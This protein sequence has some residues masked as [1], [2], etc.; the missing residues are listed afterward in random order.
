MMNPPSNTVEQFIEMLPKAELHMHLEGSLEP[1]MLLR[2]ARRNGIPLR[3]QS[4]AEVCAAYNFAN[5]A[6]FLTLYFDGCRV[7]V[8]DRD[9]SMRQPLPT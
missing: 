4:Q 9:F 2:L 7:L 1:E 3:W 8:Q 6:D 5:L